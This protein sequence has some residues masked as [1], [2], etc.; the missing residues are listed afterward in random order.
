MF[1]V[2]QQIPAHHGAFK[3]K[4][5]ATLPATEF[6]HIRPSLEL[7]SLK[8]GQVLHE[9]GDKME[10][11]YFPT[12][13]VV[14]LLCVME[15]G[16]TTETGIVGNDGVVGIELFM[17][18]DSSPNLAIVH[19]AGNAF[20]MRASKLK[21]EFAIGHAF[22]DLLLRYTLAL[23]A[24]V[25]QTAV[26]N[27]LHSVPQ[28]L[29]RWLLLSRDRLE[30]D[31]LAVTHDLIA[32]VLG[33]RRESVTTAAG[34]LSDLGLIENHRGTVTILDRRG[35][36]FAACECYNVVSAEY[37]RLLTPKVASFASPRFMR[38][39]ERSPRLQ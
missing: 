25:S 7:V 17:G 6:E 23:M 13:S 16:T 33:V 24:Q 11:V 1:L 19:S 22:H 15:N 34:K 4:L 10:Y 9:P 38:Q 32:N 2:D 28:Q 20:R 8:V 18:G 27:R 39:T 35:L 14:T 12:T 37:N 3:N 29:A 5:L 31:R 26:C 30:S 36:E 21:A